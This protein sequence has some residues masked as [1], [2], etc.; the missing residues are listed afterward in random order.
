MAMAFDMEAE[1]EPIPSEDY[2]VL[3][4]EMDDMTVEEQEAINHCRG[5]KKKSVM[6]EDLRPINSKVLE[7][8][9]RPLESISRF[10]A[11]PSHWNFRNFRRTIAALQPNSTAGGKENSTLAIRTNAERAKNKTIR[12]KPKQLNFTQVSNSLF[13]KLDES[14]LKKTNLSKKWDAKKLKL[15]TKYTYSLNLYDKYALAPNL[16]ARNFM[17]MDEDDEEN[18]NLVTENVISDVHH[19][20]DDDN[21]FDDI[22][23][24]DIGGNISMTQ[25]QAIGDPTTQD[26][27]GGGDLN[28]TVMEIS[29]NFVGAPDKVCIFWF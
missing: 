19:G 22:G 17:M 18:N 6:I 9:Y 10:W 14:K 5:L 24:D 23:C 3:N 15:P 13:Q 25:S 21:H 26:V 12:A 16:S 2:A 20:D 1:V 28:K 27:M 4:V 8:S 11:G 7:Y 29:D